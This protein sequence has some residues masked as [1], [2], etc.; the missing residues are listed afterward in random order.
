M[1]TILPTNRVS[2][3]PGVHSAWRHRN[4]DRLRDQL[5]N[6]HRRRTVLASTVTYLLPVV[7]VILGALV[8]AE[9]ITLQLAAGVA[10]VALTLRAFRDPST[11]KPRVPANRR[12]TVS[13]RNPGRVPATD[14]YAW[15]SCT[16]PCSSVMGT[17]RVEAVT[18][19]G[20]TSSKSSRSRLV[21]SQWSTTEATPDAATSTHSLS[22]PSISSIT[23]QTSH[24]GAYWHISLNSGTRSTISSSCTA[25]LTTTLRGPRPVE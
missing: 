14:S 23:R 4:R 9:P 16:T 17:R 1:R 15:V 24:P 12:E 3:H 20:Q 13:C 21:C 25:K 5:P 6:H 18:P 11:V 10:V 7:A 2:R 22:P 19:D 8:L